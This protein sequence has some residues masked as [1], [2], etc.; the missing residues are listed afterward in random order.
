V[1]DERLPIYAPTAFSPNGDEVNEVYQL[2]LGPGV[3]GIQTLS[4]FNHWGNLMYEG[5]D[6]WDGMF[7]GRRAEPAVYVYRAIIK[8]ADGSERS[9]RGDFVL[10]R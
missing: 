5:T 3:R 10:M 6:G 8:M 1:V 4:I 2:G 9:V 7:D